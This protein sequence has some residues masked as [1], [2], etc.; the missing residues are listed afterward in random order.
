MRQLP[1][2]RAPIL[3]NGSLT[4]LPILGDG[5]RDGIIETSVEGLK[6]GRADRRVG[7]VGQLGNGLTDSAVVM[8]DLGYG[9]SAPEKI[10]AVLGRSL[11]DRI[12]RNVRRA[13]RVDE[14]IQEQR[15]AVQELVLGRA[16]R[17]PRG[18]LCTRAA[19]D[20]GTIEGEELVEHARL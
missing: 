19:D 4:L 14:L 3:G 20:R 18:N 8:N 13:Q 15:Y 9:E 1:G 5:L 6:L 12:G 7:F 16:R 17:G 2:P 11:R 10:S